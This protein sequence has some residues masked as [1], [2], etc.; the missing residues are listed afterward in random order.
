MDRVAFN[1]NHGMSLNDLHAVRELRRRQSHVFDAPQPRLAQPRRVLIYSMDPWQIGVFEQFLHLALHR[2]GHL[3]VSVYYDGLLPLCAWENAQVAAP[4]ADVIARRFEF[5]YDCFG[6]AARGIRRYLDGAIARRRAESIVAA[7]SDND[8]ASLAHEG[9]AVGRI[10]RRDLTQYTLGLFDPQSCDDWTLLRRH[11][12]HA[13]MSVDLARAVLAAERPDLVVLVNGKSVMYSY[14]YEVC[15][16]AGVQVTTWEEGVYFKTGIILANNARAI[17][18][19]VD[20]AVWDAARQRPLSQAES[21]AVDDYFA[22][23]RGQTATTYTYYDAEERDFA[24]IRAALDLSPSAVLTSIFTNIVWDTNALD[25]DDAFKNMLDWVFVTIDLI[26][27]QPGG[28]LIVRAHPGET[29]LPFQTRTTVRA[30]IEQRYGGVPSHVRVID[31]ASQFSSY[32]IARHSRRC[33]VYTSTL[34]IEFALMGLQPLVCGLPYYARKGFTNDVTDREQYARW[35]L[36]DPAPQGSDPV[37]LRRFMHLV[38]F[39]LVKQPEFFDGIHGSP[40]QPR[41][42]IE[43]FE[44][45]PESM[46]IFNQIVDDLLAGGSFIHLDDAVPAAGRAAPLHPMTQRALVPNRRTCQIAEGSVLTT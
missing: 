32:E 10:A 33:A 6:I 1:G 44:G 27:R 35:L 16:A 40:Q 26:S 15:R 30:L 3:P 31:G 37:L 5:M 46:P 8:L 38:L 21:D 45:W 14:L 22:R 17:D 29:R 2:R 24:R 12:V 28:V 7:T 39:R 4:A 20:D 13:I 42:R 9:I 34:G 23:W 41:I 43:S 11:L 25:K 36:T 18:F 19:P